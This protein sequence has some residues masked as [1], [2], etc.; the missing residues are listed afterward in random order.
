MALEGEYFLSF[1]LPPI[2]I[3]KELEEESCKPVKKQVFTFSAWYNISNSLPFSSF[4][5]SR[6]STNALIRPPD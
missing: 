3:T 6:L 1:Q 2:K 4:N 5:N